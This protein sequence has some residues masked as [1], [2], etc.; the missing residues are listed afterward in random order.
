M[1]FTIP[2]RIYAITGYFIDQEWEYREVLLGFEPLFGTH[3]G[4]NL[5]EVVLLILE[6]HQITD[7]VLAVTTDNASNNKT[8]I[9]AVNDSIRELQLKTDSTIIQVPC[10]AHVIQLSLIDLLGKIKA[11]PKNDTAELVWSDERVRLLRARQQKHKIAD[12]LN[13]VG[14]YLIILYNPLTIPLDS[15]SCGL[16]QRKSST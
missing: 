7:C 6:K 1:D 15:R 4:V 14:F 2:G 8:L 11:S 5:G 10:L 13:K 12:T 9:A 3:S 16:Y